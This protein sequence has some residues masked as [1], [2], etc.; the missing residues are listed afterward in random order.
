MM[1]EN[2]K[3]SNKNKRKRIYPVRLQ[4]EHLS[5][6]AEIEKVCFSSPWSMNSLELLLPNRGI[7]IGAVALSDG[8]VCAY[9][10]MLCV[11]DEGQITNIATLPEMRN[12]GY[13]TAVTEQLIRFAKEERL[14]TV[15]LEVR[16][17]NAT[18][19]SMYKRLGFEVVGKRKDFYTKPVESALIMCHKIK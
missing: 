7:G 11:L 17:S 19:I 15:T 16:E 14:V 10:G 5:E 13:G 4:K 18:A 8:K 9:G 1:M 6:V 12:M 2:N 3:E